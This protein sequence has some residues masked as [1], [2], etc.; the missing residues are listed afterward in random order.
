MVKSI[1][2]FRLQQAKHTQFETNMV[3]I[4]TLFSD[5]NVSKK[6]WGQYTISN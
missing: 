3:K 6:P 5:Q 4:Y 2:Y 1:P